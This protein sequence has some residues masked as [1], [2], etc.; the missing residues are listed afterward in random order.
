MTLHEALVCRGNQ[1]SVLAFLD[2]KKAYD[3]V[4]HGA[5]IVKL[6]KMGVG[7]RFLRAITAMY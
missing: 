3:R 5:M 7:G 4:N 1:T 2:L 6:S